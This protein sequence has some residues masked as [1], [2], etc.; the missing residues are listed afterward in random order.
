MKTTRIGAFSIARL[1]VLV[2]A[3][4]SFWTLAVGTTPQGT[5]PQ[6]TQGTYYFLVFSNPV[7]GHE[8]EY[9]DWY[10][11]QHAADVVSIP[12]FVTAQRYVQ[13]DLPFFK[14][15]DVK[16][17]KYLIVYKIVSSDVE[18]VFAEVERRL[19]TG[20]TYLSPAYDRKNSQSYVYRTF[21]RPI[22][23]PGGDAPGA[24]FGPKQDYIQVVFSAMT[25]GADEKE[26]NAFYDRHHA[27]EVVAIPSFVGAQ[28]MVL[29]RPTTASIQ[30][31]KYFALYW[32]KTSDPDAL[33]QA[34]TSAGATFT[35]SPA[36]DAKA[37]RGYTYR[38]IGPE[39]NGD[40][41]RAER[42][43]ARAGK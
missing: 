20:E 14:V 24:K 10:D 3:A 7:D 21:G 19:K 33:K 22:K 41:V 43:K 18:S 25:Q 8:K 35:S 5:T 13:N 30:P 23:G 16:L 38:A 31:T 32:V 11:G 12:G 4:L 42:A 9:N 27:P 2:L 6:V 40:R 26:F 36:F 39:W 28:R 15:I 29:A 34:A 17:P 1:V 37:T